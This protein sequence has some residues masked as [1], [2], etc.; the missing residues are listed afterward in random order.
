MPKLFRCHLF[1]MPVGYKIL[2]FYQVKDMV[3]SLW[4]YIIVATKCLY[5]L[6]QCGIKSRQ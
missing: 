5:L 3:L 6:S 2:P 4:P 1:K